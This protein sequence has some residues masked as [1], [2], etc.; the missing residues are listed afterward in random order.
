MRVF[1][2]LAEAAGRFGP[3][4]VTI[5]NFDGT[6]V[7]HQELFRE[8]T[9]LAGPHRWTPSVL[10]FDPH[11]AH[12]VAPDRAPLRITT[13]EERLRVMA[14]CGMTQALILPFDRE[15]SLVPPEAFVREILVGA[16]G[17]KAVV[18]GDNFRFGHK[19]AGDIHLLA[20][21]GLALGFSTHIEP[22]VRWRGGIV[23]STAIRQALAEGRVG[24]AARLMGQPY[25]LSGEVVRGFGIGSKQTVP[26]L[27]LQAENQV[28]P[29]MGVYI[30][31][32]REQG[33]GRVWNSITNVGM[34]PTF[35][36]TA[37]TIESFVLSPFDG[38]T[39]ARISVS[40][41]RRVREERKFDSPEAL[42][43]QILRDV[44][45]ANAFHRRAASLYNK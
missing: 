35:A 17:V 2:S 3:C 7:G 19:S 44:E 18:V 31:R 25:A 8:V 36:G 30:T 24:Y 21:M 5:G 20:N 40:L 15:L 23:S 37:L 28:L 10:T 41:L 39:P 22:A 32:T 38:E 26:T 33:G 13:H 11:P 1:R 6:H 29:A 27:N 43:Q 45:R 14:E 16:L 4:A 42:R 12:V 34:R 9:L